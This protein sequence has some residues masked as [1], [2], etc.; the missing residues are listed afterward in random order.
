MRR[1]NDPYNLRS[2]IPLAILFIPKCWGHLPAT[3]ELL[4][5]TVRSFFRSII[6]KMC[7]NWLIFTKNLIFG[8][9]QPLLQLRRTVA[10]IDPLCTRDQF[11][12]LP[13]GID[14]LVVPI[15]GVKEFRIFLS[16]KSFKPI[17]GTTIESIST[18]NVMNW[19]RVHRGLIIATVRRNCSN[20]CWDRKMRLSL[21]LSQFWHF[22]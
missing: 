21:G 18:D 1:S 17:I 20:G 10:I 5:A 16:P 6:E 15:M 22:F 8:T 3:F 9:Q 13:V 12:P 11:M 2:T 7:Q 14:S 4:V 19:S